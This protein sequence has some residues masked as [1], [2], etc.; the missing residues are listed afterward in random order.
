MTEQSRMRGMSAIG[1]SF[2]TWPRW[3]L[4]LGRSRPGG[5]AVD[6]SDTPFRN[7]LQTARLFVAISRLSVGLVETIFAPASSQITQL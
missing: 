5:R 7:T 3:G 6:S 4:S 1:V 2:T